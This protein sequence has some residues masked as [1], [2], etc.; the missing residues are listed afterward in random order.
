[1]MKRFLLLVLAGGVILLACEG[2]VIGPSGEGSVSI[3]L[4]DFPLDDITSVEVVISSIE[5]HRSA[6]TGGEAGTVTLPPPEGPIDLLSLSGREEL[7]SSG[8]VA[9]GHYTHIKI[10]ISSGTVVDGGESCPLEVP[11]DKVMIP[12]PFEVNEGE[13][14]SIVLDFDAEKSVKVIKTG[15]DNPRYLLRPVIKLVSTEED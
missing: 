15:G 6:K 12:T 11:S 4:T 2:S 7:L 8:E 1:M 5:L 10:E 9:E 14:T 3:F 13:T